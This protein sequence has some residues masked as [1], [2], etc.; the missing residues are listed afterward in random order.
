MHDEFED[1]EHQ[2][3][4]WC[5]ECVEQESNLRVAMSRRAA[6]CICSNACCFS[7]AKDGRVSLGAAVYGQPVRDV[8]VWLGYAIGIDGAQEQRGEREHEKKW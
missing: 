3:E 6:L 1:V 8:C 5:S 4:P 2:R 7:F